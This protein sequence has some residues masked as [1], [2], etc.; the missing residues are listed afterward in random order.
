MK[1]LIRDERDTDARVIHEVIT[2]AFEGHPHSDGQ[3][4]D[5]VGRLRVTGDL[6]VSLVA[7]EDQKLVGF[8]AFSPVT[9]DGQ[10]FGWYGLGPV[11]VLSQRQQSGVGSKLIDEGLKRLIGLGAKGCVVLGDPLYYKRF[12][13]QR[14]D[15]LRYPGPPAEYFQARSFTDN[16]PRGIVAYSPAFQA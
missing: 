4:A 8:V 10:D 2:D 1:L 13:F 6:S 5:I 14:Y 9:I 12:G 3:E 7:L 15:A 16:V 11:A